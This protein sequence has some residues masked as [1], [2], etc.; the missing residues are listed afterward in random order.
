M[1]GP[2]WRF[3]FLLKLAYDI[4]AD[5]Y[6]DPQKCAILALLEPFYV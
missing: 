4:V 5:T 1:F 3:P 6:M 2:P